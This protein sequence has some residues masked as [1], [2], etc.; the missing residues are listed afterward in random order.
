MRHMFKELLLHE[1]ID[2]YTEYYKNAVVKTIYHDPYFLLAEEKAEMYD[3]YLYI[4]EEQDAFAVLPSV[5]R[6][7]N[8]ID[9]FA[10]ET[11]DYYDLITPHEYSG[12]LSNINDFRL[13]RRFYKS[14]KEFCTC[15]NIIF[16][17]VRFNPYSEEYKAAKEE[18]I[19]VVFSD[20][21]NWIDCTDDVLLHFQK[22]KARYVRSAI[23]SGMQCKEV[24]KNEQNVRTFFGYY[25]KAMD[26]LQA[27]R[28]LY[29]N[30]EYFLKL[31]QC[32]FT[33][34]FF[35]TDD[36]MESYF[37]G[38]IILCDRYHKRMYHHLSFRNAEAGNVHSME[39]MLW[40]TSEWAKEHGYECM[41][42]GGGS[43]QLHQ[44]KDECT[45]KRVD[46]F[47]GNVVYLPSAYQRF[48]DVFCEKY[49]EEK[50][51]GYL[52]IYRS[53]GD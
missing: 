33:K 49:P 37:S 22:R 41:H 30:Y 29:F 35:V 18:G 44:F 34:L 2:I 23:K 6:R 19:N 45:D 26:R 38:I 15:N 11:V 1:N 52:P 5:K 39:Y 50:D 13:F 47:C 51:S 4:Y 14:L 12:I 9:I 40:A 10:K 16:Q 32:E 21:Q 42:L 8:D 53:N 36:K 31:C 48:S 46:Y 43:G 17:F 28:F 24:E 20:S 25:T 7:V 27:R 3:I